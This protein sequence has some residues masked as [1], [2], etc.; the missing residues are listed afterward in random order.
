MYKKVS[1]LLVIALA[2]MTLVSGYDSN[3]E[4]NLF[5]EGPVAAS[6]DEIDPDAPQLNAYKESYITRQAAKKILDKIN[7]YRESHTP[8]EYQKFFDGIAFNQKSGVNTFYNKKYFDY[9]PTD[10]L[11]A[12]TSDD[13]ETSSSTSDEVSSSS[14]A[15]P[16]AAAVNVNKQQQP[17]QQKQRENHRRFKRDLNRVF[18]PYYIPQPQRWYL[19]VPPPMPENPVNVGPRGPFSDLSDGL[20]FDFQ[21][22]PIRSGVFSGWNTVNDAPVSQWTTPRPQPPFPSIDQ[23]IFFPTQRPPQATRRPSAPLTTTPR[24]FQDAFTSLPPNTGKKGTTTEAPSLFHS[25]DYDDDLDLTNRFGVE[26][27]EPHKCTWAIINCCGG[28]KSNKRERCFSIFGCGK[29]IKRQP[30]TCSP[31]KIRQA[32]YEKDKFLNSNRKK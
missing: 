1:F 4:N 22:D 10:E 29:L 24:P 19:P 15:G 5:D 7:N 6:L 31:D 25:S 11:K 9:L 17:V 27:N 30:D 28:Q 12:S 8:A 16:A 2:V 18:P 23:A 13:T 32:E 20:I 26:P 3:K 21:Y 14:P